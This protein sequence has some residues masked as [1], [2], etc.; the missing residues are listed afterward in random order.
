MNTNLKEYECNIIQLS[1]TG[2]SVS[3]D[4][5]F[6]S[7]IPQTSTPTADE[8]DEIMSVAETKKI[9]QGMDVLPESVFNEMLN[10][11]LAHGKYRNAF[12][13]TTMANFGVRYSDVVKLRRIDFIDECNRLR[14]SVVIKE[15]KTSKPRT[16]YINNAVKMAL[17]MHLWNGNFDPLDYLICSEGK[18]KGYETVADTNNP[19]AAL[20]I[21]GQIV[22]KLDENGN[23]IPKPL[24]RM[25]SER[26]MKDMLINDMNIPL[27]NDIR[28]KSDGDISLCTHSIRKLY[29]NK[30]DEMFI[31][32]FDSDVMYAH[33][34]AMSFL[35]WDYN[36][37]DGSG[38]TTSRYVK[39]FDKMKRTLNMKMNLGIDVLS[40][41]FEI[42][43]QKYLSKKN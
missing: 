18:H 42:E 32:D 10:Q 31:N 37:S 41:Y 16:M 2:E 27:I 13:L 14:D 20:R 11:C 21:N 33:T 38:K 34:A 22:Y 9:S 17:L 35:A 25:Q 26:I 7:L 5:D 43:K 12:W 6:D 24:S 3:F 39:D 30:V 15:K 36:H 4:T 23:K 1:R 8:F 28:T 29:G 19:R 40:K